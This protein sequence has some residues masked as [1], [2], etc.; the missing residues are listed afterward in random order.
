MGTIDL[1]TLKQKLR[2]STFEQESVQEEEES[3]DNQ[4]LY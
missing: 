4:I 1:D 3:Q 2:D